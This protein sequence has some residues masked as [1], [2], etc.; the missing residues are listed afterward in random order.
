MPAFSK[1]GLIAGFGIFNEHVALYFHKGA[2]MPD[3]K[4]IFSSSSGTTMRT[5]RF[6]DPKSVDE[7]TITAYVKNAIAVRES[8]R[9]IPKSTKPVTVPS[10][11]TNALRKNAKARATFE[12]LSPSKKGITPRGSLKQSAPKLARRGSK[13]PSYSSPRENRRTIN[14]NKFLR[15]P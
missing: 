3:P 10:D 4:K 11:L 1:N 7:K 14:T 9:K 12:A 8:G 2:L 15:T 6:T 5:I 13:N